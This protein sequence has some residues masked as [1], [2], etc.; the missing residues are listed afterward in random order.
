VG[1]EDLHLSSLGMHMPA[2]AAHESSGQRMTRDEHSGAYA[3]G[4][5]RFAP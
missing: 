5:C 4:V 3:E 2:S 1:D